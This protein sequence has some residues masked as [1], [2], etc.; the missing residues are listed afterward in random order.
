MYHAQFVQSLLPDTQHL[1][2]YVEHYMF[3]KCVCAGYVTQVRC[4][5]LFCGLFCTLIS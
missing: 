4:A 1:L 2:R 5:S 3:G